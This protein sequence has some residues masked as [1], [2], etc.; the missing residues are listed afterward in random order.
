MWAVAQRVVAQ[1]PLLE[2]DLPWRHWFGVLLT[3]IR[4]R[5]LHHPGIARHL[6]VLGP[7]AGTQ[8][9]IDGGTRGLGDADLPMRRR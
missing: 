6:V 3:D 4:R 8:R 9:V 7:V 2:F 1:I 5:A